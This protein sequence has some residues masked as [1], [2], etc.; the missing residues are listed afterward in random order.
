MPGVQVMVDPVRRYYAA[1]TSCRRV[2]G[3]TGRVDERTTRR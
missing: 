3:Y 1:A 2:L